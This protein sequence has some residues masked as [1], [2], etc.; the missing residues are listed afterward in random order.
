[1]N[2]IAEILNLKNFNM[3]YLKDLLYSRNGYYDQQTLA[4]IKR[5]R[6][7]HDNLNEKLSF[8]GYIGEEKKE[9]FTNEKK[10]YIAQE[11]P[12]E[13]FEYLTNISE[14]TTGCILSEI[15]LPSREIIQ[16]IPLIPVDTT[17]HID[18]GLIQDVS[19]T[20]TEKEPENLLFFR[21]LKESQENKQNT[22]L[23]EDVYNKDYVD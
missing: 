17:K 5:A 23:Q 10:P 15:E 18:P 13:S 16:D 11:A 14:A 8:L 21:R 1:M 4:N 6:E 9:F 20:V 7:L 12:I 22:P 19:F 2:T 3:K